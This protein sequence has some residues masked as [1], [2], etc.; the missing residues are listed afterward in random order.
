MKF[1]SPSYEIMTVDDTPID[2]K[3]VLKFIE[4]IGRVCYK[5]EDRITDESAEQFVRN[6][7][8][9]GHESIIEHYNI[10]VRF[11]CDRGVSHEIVR[12]RLAAYSQESTRYCNY[13][14][15]KFG[16]EL[17]FIIEPGFFDD[18]PSEYAYHSINEWKNTLQEIEYCYK[19]LLE[20]GWVAQQAR[21]ILPNILKTELVM[22]ANLREWRHVL[23]LRTSKAAHPQIQELMIPL[24]KEFYNILPAVFEDVAEAC[25]R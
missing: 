2:G 14:K 22:T 15:D 1:I 6:A 24:L 23:R 21:S 8:K 3:K 16:N 25:I 13:S 5:S 20:M 11:I 9:N 7:I 17:T 12:H 10:T 18:L 19:H 4:R